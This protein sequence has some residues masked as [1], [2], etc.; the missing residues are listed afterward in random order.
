[1]TFR[2]RHRLSWNLLGIADRSHRALVQQTLNICSYPFI[3]IRRRTG[4]RVPVT[5]SDLSRFNAA[6]AATAG[7]HTHV[8]DDA[9]E[10][11]LLGDVTPAGTRAAAL[12]LFW[13]PTAAHP[14]GRVELDIRAMT[15]RPLAQ[16]V[17]LAEAAHAVDYGAMT[18]SQRSQILALFE[19]ADA[20]HTHEGWF[21]EAGE[22]DYWS[23]RGERW[24]GLFMAT[25][26][27]GLP[28]P[29]ESRQPWHY[30]YDA[31]DVEAVRRILR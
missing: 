21:E 18:E 23:W 4:Q 30:G 10:G 1:M 17:F 28:R 31:S 12:G 3:R 29:L 25:Y 16:E 22:Q 5:V 9:G 19:H 20:S 14:A 27:A 15:D 13:L 2:Y 7:S 6:M 8:H 11:H 24:M 26:A